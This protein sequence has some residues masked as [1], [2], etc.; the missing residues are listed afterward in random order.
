MTD[1]SVRGILAVSGTRW[2]QVAQRGD[3]GWVPFSDFHGA[4]SPAIERL[5]Q[6]GIVLPG[7]IR[8][9][10]LIDRLTGP[11]LRSL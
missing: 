1:L 9:R 8:V 11:R 10:A 3:I 2:I 5:G 6:Q 7:Q 4:A